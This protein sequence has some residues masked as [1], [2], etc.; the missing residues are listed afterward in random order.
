M[1]EIGAR[2]TGTGGAGAGAVRGAGAGAVR[3]AGAAAVRSAL[4]VPGDSPEKLAGALGRGAD[5]L[6]VD[7]EDAVPPAG[8][9]RARAAVAEWLNSLPASPEPA[10]VPRTVPRTPGLPGTPGAPPAR[11]RR[12]YRRFP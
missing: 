6:I 2:G 9:D 11:R 4:Y 12:P 8:K 1:D 7:L 3:G 10:A 5:A